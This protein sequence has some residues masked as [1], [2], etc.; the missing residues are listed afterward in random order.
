[1]LM[2]KV[3]NYE[4]HEVFEKVLDFSPQ[5]L[6]QKLG[7]KLGECMIG[8][9]PG[10]DLILNSPDVSRVHARILYREGQYWFT[11]LGSTDG[12]RLHNEVL[13]PTQ[14]VLLKPDD[15][16]RICNFVLVVESIQLEP[17]E[18]SDLSLPTLAL[19]ELQPSQ[20]LRPWTESSLEVRCVQIIS[21]TSQVKTFRFVAEPAVW[22]DYQPGQFVTLHLTIHGQ[23]VV[24]S[25]SI[26]SSPSRPYLLEISV[27][28]V[29][30]PPESPDAPAGLVSNW[31]HDHF[32]VGD[33]LKIS[34][35]FGEFSC[36]QTPPEKLLLIAAG[37]GITPMMSMT[38]WILDNALTTDIVFVYSARDPQDIVYR[39]ELEQFAAQQSRFKLAITL[40]RSPSGQSWFGYQGRLD[41][42]MLR[43]IAPDFGDREVYVCG[44]NGFMAATKRLLEDLQL[45]MAQY[46]E[47]SFGGP[48]VK[49]QNAQSSLVTNGGQSDLEVPNAGAIIVFSASEQEIHCSGEDSI[50]EVAEAAAIAIPNACRSGVCGVCKQTLCSG[51]VT[52]RNEP[53]ALS[54]TDQANGVILPCIARPVDRV[55]L[56]V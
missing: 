16:L 49:A 9:T 36:T 31:L 26:S 29:P 48:S 7:Q 13:L 53:R 40:T 47:E 3:I 32:K 27:K 21:E 50:L 19:A 22:F 46:H 52:Y 43:A 51:S 2:L 25:Y 10:C 5:R 20:R 38:R 23:P 35:P 34:G 28:R 39:Q 30:A 55:V 24:R 42:A 1:M 41:A 54:E 18:P 8:R 4:T 33:S 17:I 56:E 37:S 44:P 11:D 15:I 45:P 12:S 6:G 14:D